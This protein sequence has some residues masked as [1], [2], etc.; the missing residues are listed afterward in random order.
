MSSTLAA[1]ARLDLAPR[2][3]A[4]RAGARN[5]AGGRPA[6]SRRG[7]RLAAGVALVA[8]VGAG[9]GGARL[10]LPLLEHPGEQATLAALVDPATPGLATGQHIRTSFGSLTVDEA[11]IF[12]GLSSEDLGGMSHGVSSLVSSGKAQVTVVVTLTAEKAAVAVGGGQFALLTGRGDTPTSAPTRVVGTTFPAG[13]LGRRASVDGRIS[14]VTTTDGSR[15]WLQYTDP[16][17]HRVTRVALGQA[18][19][20]GADKHAHRAGAPLPL[21]PA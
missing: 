19:T 12:N 20:I 6:G 16:G 5:A 4:P 9:V 21:P 11:Q 3:V 13:Q 1:P 14:F 2:V 18:A 15:L 8:V 10:A 17:D 7:A